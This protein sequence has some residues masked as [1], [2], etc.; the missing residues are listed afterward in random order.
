MS[1]VWFTGSL[2]Y[3]LSRII[4]VPW[5]LAMIIACTLLLKQI[6][7]WILLLLRCF[8]QTTSWMTSAK[9][10]WYHDLILYSNLKNKNS[11][12]KLS[13]KNQLSYRYLTVYNN[14]YVTLYITVKAR[15]NG[16]NMSVKHPT[17]L[18]G[19]GRCLISVG[20]L[21]MQTNPTLSN[22]FDCAVQTDQTC[23]SN[24][25]QHC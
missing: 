24:I 15:S 18:G 23:L 6:S 13:T 2:I 22:M 16:S 19:I 1:P 5:I 4:S 21:S 14:R 7:F 8:Q 17:L 11:V 20:C 12:R 3:L 9:H 10:E 25:I